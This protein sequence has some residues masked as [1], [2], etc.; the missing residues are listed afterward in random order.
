MPITYKI[1][2]TEKVNEGWLRHTVELT[3]DDIVPNVVETI[4]LEDYGKPEPLQKNIDIAL[5]EF[6]DRCIAALK[7]DTK[8][9][10]TAME[11]AVAKIDIEH[12]KDIDEIKAVG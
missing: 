3:C 9:F 4:Q 12:A 10:V 6:S 2:D 1:T 5:K 11:T 7:V 8:P